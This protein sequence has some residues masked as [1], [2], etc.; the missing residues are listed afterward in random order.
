MEAKLKSSQ[1]IKSLQ[2]KLM[3]LKQ[4]SKR[5]KDNM[6]NKIMEV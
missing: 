6:Q 5:D 1:E 2:I 3:K 4:E